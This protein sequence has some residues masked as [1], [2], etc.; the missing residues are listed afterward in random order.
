MRCLAGNYQMD[1][2]KRNFL[3]TSFSLDPEIEFMDQSTIKTSTSEKYTGFLGEKPV[4]FVKQIPFYAEDPASIDERFGF[5]KFLHEKG[6]PIPKVHW[7]DSKPYAEY[8]EKKWQVFDYVQGEAVRR[9]EASIAS[10]FK[11]I[12]VWNELS[13]EYFQAPIDAAELES[14]LFKQ[15]DN[16]ANILRGEARAHLDELKQLLD[17]FR[18][19]VAGGLTDP[20]DPLVFVH[21]DFSLNNLLFEKG[22]IACVVDFDNVAKN[23]GY[24]DLAELYLTSHCFHYEPKSTHFSSRFPHLP[25][26]VD[27]LKVI[28]PLVAV[29][30]QRLLLTYVAAVY[31]ELVLLG[32]VRE[33]FSLNPDNIDTLKKNIK[34]YMENL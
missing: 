27:I 5:L 12:G 21:G 20:E 30:S 14:L 22:E 29:R 13:K 1:E 16:L 9:D 26:H 18:H 4:Y 23:L 25:G 17:E 19:C 7:S 6:F 8:K 11:M 34:A 2:K 15:I 32:F 31:V 24:R 3:V 28:E 10:A 33:D